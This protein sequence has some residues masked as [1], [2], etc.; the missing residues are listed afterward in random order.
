[1]TAVVHVLRVAVATPVRTPFDYLPPLGWQGAPPAPGVRVRVP[2]GRR[3]A[4]GVLLDVADHSDLPAHR[5]KRA[6]AVLDESPVLP[7]VLLG[8]LQWAA[9]Y[10][11]HPVGE[12][13]ASALPVALRQG[14]SPRPRRPRAWRPSLAAG[15]AQALRRAPRQA[16]LLARLREAS[17]GLVAEELDESERRALRALEEKGWVESVEVRPEPAGPDPGRDRAPALNPA[18]RTAVEAVGEAAGFA[19][20]LIEGV[21][22]SGKTEVY[23]RI[24][25]AHLARGRQAL[26]LVPEIGLTPQLV[27]RFRRRLGGPVAVLHS[28]LG[29]GERLA[30][31]ALAASGEAP[32]LVGTRSAVFTPLPRLGIVVVDEEHDLSLKQQK[33]F[34]YSARDLVVVRARNAGVPVV[35]GSATPALETLHNALSGRYRHLRLPERAGGASHPRVRVLDVRRRRLAEGLS[36]E[37]LTAVRERLARGEQSLLFLNRRGYAPT[38]LCHDCGWVAECQR[39]DARLTLYLE[40]GRLR[41]HH[42]GAVQRVPQRCPECGSGD[43]R[44]LGMGTQRV[45][46]ALRAQLPEAGIVRVD[47]DSTARRGAL[48]AALDQAASGEAQVLLGTQMLAKGHDFPNVTLVGILDA[49]QGLF[50]ADFR[51]PERMAQLVTQVAGRAGRADKPGEVLIQTHQ[52]EHPLLRA[53]VRHGYRRFAEQA[54]DERRQAE[55]PPFASLALLRAEAT[56]RDLPHAFLAEARDAA[57]ARAAPAVQVLGPVPAPMERRAGRYRAQLLLQA[58]RR[59]ELQALLDAWV[60]VLDGLRS[61]RKVRWSLD[62]DPQEVL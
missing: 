33:G 6:L 32:V 16:A 10:Y 19:V 27:A 23:L 34:R 3:E 46:Q 44:P 60:P 31:W 57:A 41:C 56:D 37:L 53:L 36:E 58:P 62:V 59:A 28:R 49:D 30:A 43:L 14:A 1:M 29:A 39:C 2:F 21:T 61:G 52:P 45:E 5:L 47:R 11:H 13:V 15:E 26:V 55:L 40:A 38:V 24:I 42:C 8:L 51:A 9:H 7:P 54:L 18:Q 35:L 48:E 22:G 50:G 4:I 25:A 12:V 20:H 17:Q